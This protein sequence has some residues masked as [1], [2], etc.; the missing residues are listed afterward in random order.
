MNYILKANEMKMYDRD[1]SER[2]GIP[3]MVLMERA[4]LGVVESLKEQNLK[5]ER[6]L[7]VAGMGNNGGDGLAV[8]RLLAEKGAEVT[9]CI[10]GNPDKMTPEMRRQLL[11]LENSGFSIQ[12]KLELAEYDMVVDALLGIGL[13]RNVEGEYLELIREINHFGKRGALILSLDIPSGVCADTGRIL[14]MAVRADITVTFAYAKRGHFLYPGRE[15]TGKLVVKNIGVTEKSFIKGR[16]GAFCYEK[17]DLQGLLPKRS[18]WG[19]KGTF[20]KV[21]LVAGSHDMCGACILCGKSILRTGA[22]M[23]KIITPA[24]NRTILQEAFP[25]AM[26]YTF[27][28]RPE[29]EKVQSSLDWADVVVAGPGLSTGDVSGELM[30]YLLKDKRCPMV[31]DADGLNL[32]AARR[33]LFQLAKE[34]GG[35]KLIITPHP[36]EL[37]RLLKTDR[38]EYGTDREKLVSELA[39]ALCCVVAAKDAATLVVE[40][41]REEIYI[42]TSGNDGM[43]TAGSGDVLAGITG[44]LL[45]QGMDSFRC[46]CLSVYL[47]GLAG[48]EASAGKGRYGMTASDIV[49]AIPTAMTLREED[50][51]GCHKTPSKKI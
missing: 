11:I 4:S 45:A 10:A 38:E 41:G 22:G 23:V 31:I 51:P 35:K 48:E 29:P 30:E 15:Y 7:V 1:T 49:E 24:C 13:S 20:G 25:E 47:H 33:E 44:G 28:D 27:E 9:F 50:F 18:P 42:N 6:I 5:P 26:L 3:S 14:G 12:R 34:R 17:K 46:A 39:G 19:N 8:G 37:V 40:A 21:L 36:G 2:I 43:A 32:L 16:P